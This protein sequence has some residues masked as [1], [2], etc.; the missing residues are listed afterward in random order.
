MHV[1]KSLLMEV[2]AVYKTTPSK[3]D[4]VVLH[5][6][7]IGSSRDCQEIFAEI[8]PVPLN[9]REAFI[10]IY[11]NRGNRTIGHTV[12]SIGGV[13]GTVVDNKII[14]QNA[15]LCNASSIVLAHNHPS[16]HRFPSRADIKITKKIKEAGEIMDIKVLDHLVITEHDDKYY[17]FADEGIL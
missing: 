1:Y 5:N 12:I 14:Y 6:V 17:S 16:G 10:C 9:H 8:F 4:N 11:L 3:K 2:Q 15:L 7:K 13:S